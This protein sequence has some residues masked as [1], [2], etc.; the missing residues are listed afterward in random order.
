MPQLYTYLLKVCKPEALTLQEL[1]RKNTGP[2][3]LFDCDES[4]WPGPGPFRSAEP[5]QVRASGL[6]PIPD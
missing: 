5:R 3:G 4:S 2:F 6:T 1:F